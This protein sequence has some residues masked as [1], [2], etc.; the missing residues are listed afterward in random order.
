MAS[1]TNN[2]SKEDDE[3]YSELQGRQIIGNNHDLTTQI[4]LHL[5]SNSI[6]NLKLTSKLWLSISHDH[7]FIKTHALRHPRRLSGVFLRYVAQPQA[8]SH[9]Y[10][11]SK[12]NDNTT[13]VPFVAAQNS[14]GLNIVQSCNGLLLCSCS[15]IE[16][17]VC[18]P[19]TMQRKQVPLPK[20]VRPGGYFGLN[21]AFDPRLSPFYKIVCV[22]KLFGHR[23]RF[24]LEVY[25]SETGQWK[26]VGDPFIETD[27]LHFKQGVFCKGVIH[28]LKTTSSCL[29]FDVN[30]ECL[31]S[32]PEPPLGKQCASYSHEFFGQSNDHLYFVV[33]RHLPNF[34]LLQM[35][36][37][38]S[39][40]FV[41][42]VVNLD[43]L[44]ETF[45][46]MAR[47]LD[48]TPRFLLLYECN[49]L[50]IE[51]SESGS[52]IDGDDLELVLS[53]P[54]KIVR[55]NPRTNASREFGELVRQPYNASSWYK[56]FLA[57]EYFETICPV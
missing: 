36:D 6:F 26:S 49:V 31:R 10:V 24:Q 19:M 46:I 40:W 25:S 39:G 2:Q 30:N 1:I 4:I 28:W 37:D 35:K 56:D 34:T 17:Y 52:D 5:P 47:N 14:L 43:V 8:S 42:N 7:L 38:Y 57:Y 44:A 12:S 23:S 16:Y 15:D 48:R 20:G 53:M 50:C 11:A 27:V 21:L 41:K 18:N 51:E 9:A 13:P 55:F 32:T 54:G 29:Y 3:Q 22:S 45:P 33:K